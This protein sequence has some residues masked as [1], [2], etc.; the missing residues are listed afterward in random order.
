[1][2]NKCK[3]S[4]KHGS[5]LLLTLM[6]LSITKGLF[7]NYAVPDPFLNLLT[8]FQ[9]TTRP[10]SASDTIPRR[11]SDSSRLFKNDTIP[12][13]DSLRT[14]KDT[15]NLKISKDTLS[16]PVQYTASDSVVMV[17]KDKKII[18]FSKANVKYT[19]VDLSADS[20]ELDQ[21][22]KMLIASYRR[23]SLT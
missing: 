16:A 22:S 5:A 9:D 23:D 19:D 12:G 14:V 13:K 17:V 7:A 4:L 8:A 2:M 11:T 20:I 10:R 18:L 3:N 21:P 15:F 6:L 1:M